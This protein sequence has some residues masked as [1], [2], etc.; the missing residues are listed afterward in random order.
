MIKQAIVDHYLLKLFYKLPNFV[1]LLRFIFFVSKK[2]I[3]NWKLFEAT[4]FNFKANI[5]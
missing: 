5:S 1:I 2:Y 3:S 4:L